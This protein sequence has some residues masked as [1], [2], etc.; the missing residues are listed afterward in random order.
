MSFRVLEGRCSMADLFH[1]TT[2]RVMRMHR[3]GYAGWVIQRLSHMNV[4]DALEWC[5]KLGMP[6]TGKPIRVRVKKAQAGGVN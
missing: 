4:S 1:A 5:Q 2:Q 3:E 6:W